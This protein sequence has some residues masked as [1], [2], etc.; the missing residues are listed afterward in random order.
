[1]NHLLWVL[2]YRYSQEEGHLHLPTLL[3]FAVP[4]VTWFCYRRITSTVEIFGAPG[5][6]PSADSMQM[7]GLTCHGGTEI[8]VIQTWQCQQGKQLDVAVLWPPAGGGQFR[9]YQWPRETDGLC[10]P[11]FREL[12]LWRVCSCWC[13][14]WGCKWETRK[15]FDLWFLIFVWLQTRF[16]FLW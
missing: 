1:M 8:A 14:W 12:R 10:W 6:N 11:S 15:R 5:L 9:R 2:S 3:L 7:C 13:G 16:F 4:Q